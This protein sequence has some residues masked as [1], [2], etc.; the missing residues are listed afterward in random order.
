L[1]MKVPKEAN[2]DHLQNARSNSINHDDLFVCVKM[3]RHNIAVWS[4]KIFYDT[5]R[6]FLKRIS[7]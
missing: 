6:V 2:Y 1:K 4:E 3:G 5:L 7:K